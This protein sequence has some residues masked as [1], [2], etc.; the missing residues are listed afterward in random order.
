MLLSLL[1]VAIVVKL[2]LGPKGIAWLAI[3]FGLPVV[4]VVA[5]WHLDAPMSGRVVTSQYVVQLVPYVKGQVKAVHARANQ[6]IK[7]GDLLLEINPEPYQYAVNQLEAQLAAARANA[8][9]AQASVEAAGANVAKAKAGVEQAEA[10]VAQAKAGLANARENVVKAKAAAVNA[11]AGV[12]KA[13]ASADL[14][15]T[16]ERIVRDVR[17]QDAGAVSALKVN[18]ATD[19]RKVA[20]AAV[21]QARAGAAEAKA[22]V[23]QAEAA[24]T[25]SQAAVRQAEAGLAEAE[26]A[27]QQAEA[28]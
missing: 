14:A 1:F 4:A 24:V 7:K 17:K 11:E 28:A 27:R 15:K 6:P 21:E 23:G 5:L 18:Q 26:S 25:Q 16:E 2:K 22:A 10:G 3:G 12:T 19:N 20:D 8:G 9:Q 13:K